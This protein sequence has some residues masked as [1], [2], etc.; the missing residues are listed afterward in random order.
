MKLLGFKVTRNVLLIVLLGSVNIFAQDP[1]RFQ[2]EVENITS[3]EFKLDPDKETVVFTGSSSIRMW[4]TVQERFPSINAINTG[5]GG[6]HMSDLLYY[7]DELVLN[8]KPDRVFIY[9][10]DNDIADSKSPDEIMVTTKEVISRI[11]EKLPEVEIFL[12]SAKPS[13]LRW[14]LKE[15]YEELNNSFKEFS[16]TDSSTVYVDVWNPMLEEDGT[17]QQDL[18]LEDD[19]HMN[20]KGYKIWGEVIVNHIK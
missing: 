13:I 6:S 1:L 5:F 9:E 16:E 3:H 20:E 17:L 15:N 10:G 12:I 2:E 18:F 11:K 4:K 14:H 8:Y 7:L 19:L